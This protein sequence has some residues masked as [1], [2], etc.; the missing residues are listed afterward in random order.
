MGLPHAVIP[1]S[2]ANNPWALFRFAERSRFLCGSDI[3][4]LRLLATA[5]RFYK[6]GGRSRVPLLIGIY[7]RPP[8]RLLRFSFIWSSDSL[9]SELAMNCLS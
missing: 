3:V 7:F 2:R 8:R 4:T 6:K 1:F 5:P 9:L